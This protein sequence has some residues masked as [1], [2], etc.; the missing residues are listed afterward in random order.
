MNKRSPKKNPTKIPPS[1]SNVQIND[2]FK[3]GTPFE[4]VAKSVKKR[5]KK[6]KKEKAILAVIQ[7]FCKK[8]RNKKRKG[9]P[10][11]TKEQVEENE[12]RKVMNIEESI[13]NKEG[14]SGDQEIREETPLGGAR[15][16]GRGG[17]EMKGEGDTDNHAVGS[18]KKS[19]RGK[20]ENEDSTGSMVD[21]VKKKVV[22]QASDKKR[23][24][25][26]YPEITV[27]SKEEVVE[28]GV[29]CP[30][31]SFSLA[32]TPEVILSTDQNDRTNTSIVFSVTN[33][34]A[35]HDGQLAITDLNDVYEGNSINPIHTLT[36][37]DNSTLSSNLQISRKGDISPVRSHTFIQSPIFEQS[38]FLGT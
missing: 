35:N 7:R 32:S 37:Y 20:K 19:A 2:S 6:G 5:I 22:A 16:P 11:D 10:C 13:T 4:A 27:S 9:S 3:V 23:V 21:C 30:P 26:V 33:S 12:G 36:P 24:S 15:G 31:F 38:D 17:D 34:S 29:M 18:K 8:Q 25:P 28:T 1:T 14:I